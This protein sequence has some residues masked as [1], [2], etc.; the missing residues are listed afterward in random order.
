MQQSRSSTSDVKN[1][2]SFQNNSLPN[3]TDRKETAIGSFAL[4]SVA[5]VASIFCPPAAIIAISAGGVGIG[6]AISSRCSTSSP[7]GRI[8]YERILTSLG[9]VYDTQVQQLQ[10]RETKFLSRTVLL[11]SQIESLELEIPELSKKQTICTKIK[12]DVNQLQDRVEQLQRDS[13]TILDELLEASMMLSR[14]NIQVKYIA[15]EL[16]DCGYARTRRERLQENFERL[17]KGFR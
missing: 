10:A 16:A 1:L 17:L 15:S 12:D 5:A 7:I 2:S 6:S 9:S 11:Q 13:Q 4:A 8:F 3:L 14:M